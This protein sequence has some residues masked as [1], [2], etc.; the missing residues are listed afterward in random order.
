MQLRW[1]DESDKGSDEGKDAY[2][3]PMRT[4]IVQ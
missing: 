3:A 1:T 4:L 2:W